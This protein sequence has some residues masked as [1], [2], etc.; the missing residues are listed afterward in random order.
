MV[1]MAMFVALNVVFTRLLSARVPIAGIETVRIGLGPL[2][3]Y[4]AGIIGGPIPGAIVGALGDIIGAILFP[5]GGYL[6]HFTVVAALRGLLAGLL[7]KALRKENFE[8]IIMTKSP[9]R[10]WWYLKKD[11]WIELGIPI[12]VPGLVSAISLSLL[13]LYLFNH[14][15][16]FTLPS[17]LLA[18]AILTP[19]YVYL[20]REVLKIYYRNNLKS[21]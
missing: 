15:I 18:F 19:V 8:E 2:P 16:L 7:F 1:L 14:P 9:N 21:K 3:V 5:L 10:R 12:A 6:P 4:I 11:I 20:G 17:H 13:T